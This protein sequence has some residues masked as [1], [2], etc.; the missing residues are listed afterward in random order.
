MA[1]LTNMEKYLY[2][3]VGMDL[4]NFIFALA[5]DSSEKNLTQPMRSKIISQ[6]EGDEAKDAM[7]KLDN[8]KSATDVLNCAHDA[9]DFGASMMIKSDKKRE[10][11]IM[12][13]HI[14]AQCT[15]LFELSELPA[16]LH[17]GVTVAYS[18]VNGSLIHYPGKMTQT[19]INCK[20]TTVCS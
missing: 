20:S 12:S 9:A 8:A 13:D 17:M 1:D 5:S 3:T 10:K 14:E 19:V 18:L 6:L 2:K 16:T 4:V 15:R 11:F 7:T